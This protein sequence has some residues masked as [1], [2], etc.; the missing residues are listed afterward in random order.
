MVVDKRRHCSNCEGFEAFDACDRYLESGEVSLDA[1]L[2][3]LLG[4]GNVYLEARR[5]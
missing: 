1:M 2:G 4:G 5:R 3:V